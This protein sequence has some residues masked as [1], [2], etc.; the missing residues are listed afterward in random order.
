MLFRNYLSIELLLNPAG[1]ANR[2]VHQDISSGISGNCTNMHA[3][4]LDTAS[5]TLRS[6]ARF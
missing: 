2:I 5:R 6:T 1:C 4:D 3:G